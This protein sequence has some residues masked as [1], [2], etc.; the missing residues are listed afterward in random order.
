MK[1]F[2]RASHTYLEVDFEDKNEVKMLG[3]M[4]DGQRKKWF[5]PPGR[6]LSPFALWLPL[7]FVPNVDA[8]KVDF[9]AAAAQLK[10]QCNS[11]GGTGKNA[12]HRPCPDCN[13]AGRLRNEP[14]NT[15]SSFVS[16]VELSSKPQSS[17]AAKDGWKIYAALSNLRR[18]LAREQKERLFG[19]FDDN[20]LERIVRAQPTSEIALH[21]VNGMSSTKVRRFG[22]RIVACILG[23]LM[24][25][26]PPPPRPTF[27][28][29]RL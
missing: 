13:G 27:S 10:E 17:T 1:M 8:S 6:D 5:V 19:I 25:G 22:N 11:C 29:W 3:A 16:R 7:E 14:P 26:E 4:W 20:V 15:P 24:P 21:R 23:V 12:R 18:Q 2:T 9:S 28:R